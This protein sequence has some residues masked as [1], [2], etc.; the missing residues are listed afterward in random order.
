M[1]LKSSNQKEEPILLKIS[2]I[3]DCCYSIQ[4]L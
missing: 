4:T 1:T 2:Y 3:C